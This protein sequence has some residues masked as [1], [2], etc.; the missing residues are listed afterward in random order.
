MSPTDIFNALSDGSI[1]TIDVLAVVIVVGLL[2]G[3]LWRRFKVT[4]GKVT[5]GGDAPDPIEELRA[6]VT[7][8]RAGYDHL[9]TR[10]SHLEREI[11]RLENALRR[12]KERE[13]EL[14]RQLDVERVAAGRRIAQLEDQLTEARA[15]IAALEHQLTSHK[16]S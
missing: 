10:V 13:A 15:R 12:A 16:A 6:I 11:V 7:E 8:Q 1:T 9:V 14:E 4:A 5:I 3:L 2:I